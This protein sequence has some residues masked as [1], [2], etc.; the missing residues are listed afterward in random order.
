MSSGSSQ[1]VDSSALSQQIEA[2]ERD[3]GGL[4]RA[5]QR[6]RKTR[7]YLLLGFVVL[8]AAVLFMFYRLG[9]K[10]QQKRFLG[11]L[12][13]QVKENYN[14]PAN[15]RLVMA[16]VDAFWKKA[17]PKLEAQWKTLGTE[18]QALLKDRSAQ[19]R[20][21]FEKLVK[22][23]G[24]VLYRSVQQKLIKR[25]EDEQAAV[26]SRHQEILMEEFP[27]FLD[28]RLHAAMLNNMQKAMVNLLQENYFHEVN[29]EVTKILQMWDTFPVA[30]T[31]T[32]E[33]DDTTLE[34]QLIGQLLDLA[35]MKLKAAEAA[36][37]AYQGPPADAVI[38]DESAKRVREAEE[39]YRKTGLPPKSK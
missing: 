2:I 35:L 6:T 30:E 1:T 32:I 11:A 28:T 14:N 24:D 26:I 18:L 37:K 27:E 38:E 23:Q 29:Q 25:F 5:L 9:S 20:P 15:K 33:E 12:T 3:A 22:D 34:Q 19:E 13:S 39:G 21:Q 7:F 31:P 36:A 17:R 16:E 4:S 8:V 10:F